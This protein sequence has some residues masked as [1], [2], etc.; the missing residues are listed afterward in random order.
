[1]NEKFEVPDYFFDEPDI[2]EE[3]YEY[4]IIEESDEEIEEKI[5]HYIG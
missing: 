5:K 4:P 2:D 3:E 1:M